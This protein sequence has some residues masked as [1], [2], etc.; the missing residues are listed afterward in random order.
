MIRLADHRDTKIIVELL[1]EFLKET[2]YVQATSA[3][4]DIEHLCKLTW[5]VQQHGDIWLAFDDLT[6]VGL[7]MAVRQPNMWVA[8]A[9]EYRE[10]VWF[11]M[12]EHRKSQIGGRLFVHYCHRAEELMK[13]KKIQGYFT[14]QMTT[15]KSIDLERRGFKLMERTYLKDE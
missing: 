14:T 8:H 7:L 13:Q 12:P 4:N 2:S 11:V 15:T 9:W 5:T 3:I 1:K 10:L 6:P